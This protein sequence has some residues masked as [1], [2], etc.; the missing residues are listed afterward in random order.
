MSLEK[1]REEIDRIDNEVIRL[2]GERMS[3]SAKIAEYKRENNLPILDA[4]REREKLIDITAK[5]DEELRTYAAS[6]YSLIFDISRSYQRMK[7]ADES[8]LVNVIKN[9][10]SSTPDVFPREAVVACQGIEGA[11]S[12][13]A[14][15]RIFQLPNIMFCNTFDGVFSAIESGL[16][17]Y[18]MVPLENST[19]GSINKVYDLMIKHNFSVVRSVRLKVD[20]ALLA[21]PGAE[22]S[23]IK[24]IYSH[25]QAVAQC[26]DYLR[27]LDVRVVPCENTAVAAKLVR[28]SGRTDIAALSSRSCAELYGLSIL[29]DAVQDNG[30][31]YTRFICISKKLEIY[32]G[33]DKTSIMMSVPHKPGSLYKVLSRFYTL[34]INLVKLESRPLP[35]SNF[36]FMFYFDLETPV[37]SPE[38]MQMISD[39]EAS[40]SEFRYLGSYTEV[41]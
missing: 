9:A 16:C 17:S 36:E 41:V 32:P 25:E 2:F 7:T 40:G 37:Y 14:C 30:N 23:G 21:N 15:E 38:F 19:A 27:S 31:N 6:L 18:G 35:D 11:Y 33:A 3:A 8:P 24:E 5:T 28:D 1:L 13:Q 4:T 26:A 39:L 34:G 22:L 12:Q 10:L 20:H 29:A